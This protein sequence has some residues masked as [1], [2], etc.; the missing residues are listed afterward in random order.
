MPAF[1]IPSIRYYEAARLPTDKSSV[2]HLPIPDHASYA[3]L[4]PF[5]L[6]LSARFP[7]QEDP[8][9]PLTPSP[10]LAQ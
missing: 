4:G 7:E 1:W 5:L 8:A 10:Y 6:R 2:D 3:D 9:P